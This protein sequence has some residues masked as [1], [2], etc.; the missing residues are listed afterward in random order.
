MSTLLQVQVIP[1]APAPARSFLRQIQ[2]EK[3]RKHTE[4]A[5]YH[6]DKDSAQGYEIIEEN[7]SWSV[8]CEEISR[9]LEKRGITAEATYISDFLQAEQ[10][11]IESES[12]AKK[13]QKAKADKAEFNLHLSK[14]TE[15][16]A[17]LI[18]LR[19]KYHYTFTKISNL[20]NYS[21]QQADN[22]YQIAQA[23]FDLDD[24]QNVFFSN[25]CIHLDSKEQDLTGILL[26]NARSRKSNAGR[27]TKAQARKNNLAMRVC[28]S[29]DILLELGV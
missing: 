5:E 23:A 1:E 13:A 25:H 22:L 17:A 9:I 16:Q 18:L 10:E 27:P 15:L 19:L 28:N 4:N 12:D 26:K 29:G 20:L 24:I 6:S 11:A 2:I 8:L 21:D 14:L 7:D 3:E